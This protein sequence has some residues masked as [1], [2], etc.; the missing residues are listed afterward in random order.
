MVDVLPAVVPRIVTEQLPL[1]A[2]LDGQS[3]VVIVAALAFVTVGLPAAIVKELDELSFWNVMV[4]WL[5]PE[6]H[7]HEDCVALIDGL[8]LGALVP[9]PIA[10]MA[11]FIVT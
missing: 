4:N 8:Q 6:L 7:D 1:A 3:L 2:M 10:A 11:L 9:P 5:T